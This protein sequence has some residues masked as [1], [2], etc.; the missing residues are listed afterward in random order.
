MMDI[1]QIKD[2]MEVVGSD[3]EHVGIVDHLDG[4]KI[5]LTHGD[6][7]AD[8]KHHFLPQSLIAKVDEYVTLSITAE[9]ALAQWETEA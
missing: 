3:G 4:D 2:H 1:S 5:K 8:G 9:E 6:S 7:N